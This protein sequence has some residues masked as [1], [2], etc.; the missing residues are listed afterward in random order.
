MATWHMTM[1]NANGKYQ[2]GKGKC[3]NGNGKMAKLQWQMA[4][5]IHKFF[6]VFL[7]SLTAFSSICNTLSGSLL[8]S[9]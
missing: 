4:K 6:F 2:N 8:R 1:A 9:N 5:T 7:F 3:R